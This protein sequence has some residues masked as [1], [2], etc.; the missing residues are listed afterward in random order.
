[1]PWGRGVAL[2]AATSQAR[3]PVCGCRTCQGLF[4]LTSEDKRVMRVIL[5][6]PVPELG[7]AGDVKNVRPGHARNFLLP[8][9]LAVPASSQQMARLARL[10]AEAERAAE[11]DAAEARSL[12]ERLRALNVVI[13]AT[14]GE[15]GRLHGTVTSPQVAAALEEQHQI[16]INRRDVV[17]RD[18]LRHL[19]NHQVAIRLPARQTATLMVEIVPDVEPEAE[20]EAE[21]A[22]PEA[23]AGDLPGAEV[24]DAPE[25]AA[26]PAEAAIPVVESP[27]GEAAGE[28]DPDLSSAQAAAED[29]VQPE[30]AAAESAPT[31][32]V[33]EG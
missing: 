17:L 25:A 13:T 5:V 9:G 15:G 14:V 27:E 11:R 21:E 33:A 28:P 20:A 18:P 7:R 29:S 8:R 10:R 31:S 32:D 12:A 26:E 30:G 2:L 19:G 3:Q 1:M 24:P 22:A 16:Q 4:T 6:E 23:A